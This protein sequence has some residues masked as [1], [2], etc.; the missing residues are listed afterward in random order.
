MNKR[1]LVILIAIALMII[2][3]LA[4][5]IVRRTPMS[6]TTSDGS[7]QFTDSITGQTA[8]DI[9]GEDNST[10]L[11]PDTTYQSHVSINGIDSLYEDLTNDQA[12][13]VQTT[14][15]NYLMARSGL[16]DVQGEIKGNTI[17]QN[18]NQLQFTLVI[19]KPQATYQVTVQA[20]SQYQSIPDV[21]FKQ[22]E[23]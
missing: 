15:N 23:Q 21:T 11:A 22:V 7:V 13:S 17:T 14:M 3:I 12:S 1:L 20:A 6:S 8:T 19:I 16:A 18:G 9:V 4:V 2:G 10:N 5:L